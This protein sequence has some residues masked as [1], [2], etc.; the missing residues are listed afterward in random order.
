VL[1]VPLLRDEKPVGALTVAKAEPAP[2]SDRQNQLLNTFA[3][4]ALIAI[5]NVRLFETE[6]QRKRAFRVVGTADGNV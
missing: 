2:F 3:D 5:E 4:Q 1:A 6:Q